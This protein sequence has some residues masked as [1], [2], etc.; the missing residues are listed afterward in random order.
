MRARKCS[1][2][3]R[4]ASVDDVQREPQRDVECRRRDLIEATDWFIVKIFDW[5]RDDVVATDDAAFGRSLFGTDLDLGANTTDVLAIGAHVTELDTAMAA[6]RV[7]MQTGRRPAGGPRSAQNM[8]LRA[9]TPARSASRDGV[10]I[11][12]VQAQAADAGTR[13]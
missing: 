6:S 5:H 11:E 1:I 2:L 3:S 12:R 4:L 10:P 8:S 9:T 7:R 13:R